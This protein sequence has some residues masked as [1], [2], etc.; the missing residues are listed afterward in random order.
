MDDDGD[1]RPV[2]EVLGHLEIL[3]LD[4]WNTANEHPKHLLTIIIIIIIIIM[5]IIIIIIT[6][7]PLHHHHHNH[8]MCF[9]VLHP[10]LCAL[11]SLTNYWDALKAR[12]EVSRPSEEVEGVRVRLMRKER[13]V[14]VRKRKA[15]R[16]INVASCAAILLVD[17]SCIYQGKHLIL[18]L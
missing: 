18:E 5:F 11:Y 9:P 12:R 1:A 2:K 3:Q 17:F 13:G 4:C 6:I 16:T 14:R 15:M 8:L 7:I 10:G